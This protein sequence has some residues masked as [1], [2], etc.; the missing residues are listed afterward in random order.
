VI[1]GPWA[2]FYRRW[3]QLEPPLRPHP[4]VCA[5]V[6]R[7]IAGHADRALL[8]GMTPEFAPLAAQTV[9]VDWSDKALSVIW[10]GNGPTQHALKG[11]WLRLP[12]TAAV[13]SAAIGDGSF[14][15]LEYPG[16]YECVFDELARAVRP[17]G[18]IVV[19]VYLTP[20][21]CDLLPATRVRTMAGGVRNIHELKWR[22]A[23]ALCAA[24]G[25]PNLPV[26]SILD[27]FN[28]TFPDRLALRR[29]TGWTGEE[30]AQVD[31]YDRL[32]DVFSFPTARQLLT[33]AE[34]FARCRL[35]AAGDYALAE[36][37]PLL[38]MDLD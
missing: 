9:A 36:R 8:L 26:T 21:P 17:G 19:R 22:V 18:R 14:N 20:D 1:D 25:E 27:G 38:V 34:R 32:P 16:D 37:C 4:D 31:A 10:A 23:N 35:V 24:S 11:N 13:F 33:V 6:R 15:C 2:G 30:V 7:L 3:R 29:A 5:A 28:R 12:C